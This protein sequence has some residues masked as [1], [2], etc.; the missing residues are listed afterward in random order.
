MAEGFITRKSGGSNKSN[1]PE[2]A[3]SG[4][5]FI[6]PVGKK[7]ENVPMPEEALW[8][9]S[10]GVLNFTK[11]VYADVYLIGG[12]GGGGTG[13]TTTGG[14]GGG[15]GGYTYLKNN[16]FIPANCNFLINIGKG[17]SVS[18][19]VR[20]QGGYGEATTAF[21]FFANGGYGGGSTDPTSKYAIS[22]ERKDRRYL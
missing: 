2:Y 1:I 15:G 4:E 10:S 11:N 6:F 13:G 14:G 9:T 19:N 21:G 17:G 16:V 20:C 3:Y 22:G 18:Y 12:G 5:S 8:L 7:S